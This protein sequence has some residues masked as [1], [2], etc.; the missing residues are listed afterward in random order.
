MNPFFTTASRK[1]K[2]YAVG[3]SY[4][5]K[6]NTTEAGILANF[7]GNCFFFI[8]ILG[9]SFISSH[10]C[11]IW[12]CNIL[13]AFLFLCGCLN[14]DII[15]P[16]MHLWSSSFRLLMLQTAALVCD[17]LEW[18]LNSNMGLLKL[19]LLMRL[20]NQLT[21]QALW[22]LLCAWL[23]PPRKIMKVVWISGMIGWYLIMILKFI[24]SVDWAII[25]FY[26][27]LLLLLFFYSKQSSVHIFF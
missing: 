27:Y 17:N 1:L 25:V 3:Q 10:I 8:I 14:I 20:L 13:N 26:S 2:A 16:H 19:Q 12:D 18:Y 22:A 9:V 11:S 15:S 7:K 23:L 24:L 21:S 6:L 4:N 5:S